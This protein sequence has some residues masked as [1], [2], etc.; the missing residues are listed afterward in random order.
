MRSRARLE[1]SD[2]SS[3]YEYVYYGI[4]GLVAIGKVAC[5]IANVV[6]VQATTSDSESESESI[7]SRLFNKSG[8]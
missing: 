2:G 4:L 8:V 5:L 6:E 7:M 3:A 1:K